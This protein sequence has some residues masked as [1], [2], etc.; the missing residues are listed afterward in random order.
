MQESNQGSEAERRCRELSSETLS[1]MCKAKKVP[2]NNMLS[3]EGK[4]KW[5]C[6]ISEYPIEDA[7]RMWNER[8]RGEEAGRW[9]PHI[10]NHIFTN[11]RLGGTVASRSDISQFLERHGERTSKL[12][13][14][15]KELLMMPRFDLT[16]RNLY[17]SPNIGIL[18]TADAV[19]SCLPFLSENFE[20]V[21]MGNKAVLFRDEKNV[22]AV[23]PAESAKTYE[24]AREELEEA[25]GMSKKELKDEFNIELAESLRRTVTTRHY[26][27][28]KK[29]SAWTKEDYARALKIERLNILEEGI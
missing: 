6:A 15:S 2:H 29:R 10:T 16:G 17:E 28:F 21:E 26:N 12:V 13:R 18:V 24:L 4:A 22:C 11:R 23:L 5:C 19:D 14:A 9:E 8:Y 25:E 7:V 3:K 20:V 27:P 1:G